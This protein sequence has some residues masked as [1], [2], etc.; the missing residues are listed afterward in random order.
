[1]FDSKKKS[2]FT[3][4]KTSGAGGTT[5]AT[6]TFVQAAKKKS[7]ETRSG[8]DALKYKTT[9]NP[10]VDQFGTLGNYKAPR[11]FTDIAADCEKLWATGKHRIVV[12]FMLYIRMITRVV[13][14][15]TGV[16]TKVSQ[17]GAELKHEGIMRMIWLHSKH[18]GAF[19]KNIGLFV[20]VGSWKDVITMLQY[21]LVYHGWDERK[22]NW[23]KFGDL[24]LSA[25]KNPGTSELLKKYLPQIKANSAC[26][27]VDSQADNMIAKWICSLVFGPK[28]SAA[29]YKQYRKLKS[30]GTAHEWQKLISKR[31]FNELDFATIHG[32]AL[33][34]LVRSKFLKNQGLVE[35]YTEWV[36]KPETAVKFTGFV[37]EIFKGLGAN[38]GR[39]SYGEAPIKYASLSAIPA[40]EQE[41]IN[42]Q[43][44][45]LIEKAGTTEQNRLVVVRDTS[46]SMASI[47]PGTEMSCYAVAKALALYFSEF[48]KGEF[49]KSWIEFNNTAQMHTWDG[50]T[51]LEK[52]FNDRSGI[53]GS[54]NFL[55]V[56]ELFCALQSDIPEADFPTGILCISD[57]EFNPGK[58]LSKTNVEQAKAM[59]TK[60]GFSKDYVDNF[61]I[62]LWNLQNR[63]YGNDSGSKFETYG[64]VDGVYYFSGYSAATVSF[65]TSK[66]KNASELFDAAMSQEILD[67]VEI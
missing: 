41:T 12:C 50:Q 32:R 30:S 16:S 25:L 22:L 59:L 40:H 42:K 2:L 44:A 5:T 45:T 62:V 21:D 9:G 24:I 38:G 67:M 58:D 52:W 56:I 63:H 18:E 54:T 34:I 61:V 14:L 1:M 33:S 43:F 6:A 46:G 7:A 3:T 53:V 23:S 15:F 57:G 51:P 39:G 17:K 47:A 20:S 10:F 64:D 31:S 8:N 29:N 26:T 35:R 19:W 13:T 27:T 55:G 66:I 28:E 11:S 37:H 36:K 49:G 60:A 48:L 65:L 4:P